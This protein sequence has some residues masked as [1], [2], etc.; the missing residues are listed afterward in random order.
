LLNQDINRLTFYAKGDRFHIKD[1]I[2]MSLF[3]EVI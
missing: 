3:T 2:F 1:N